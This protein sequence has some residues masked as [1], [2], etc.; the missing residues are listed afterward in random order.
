M[1][2]PT[3]TPEQVKFKLVKLL[4]ELMLLKNQPAWSELVTPEIERLHSEAIDKLDATWYGWR[5]LI[6]SND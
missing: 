5:C 6:G 2:E 4:D 1:T 3:L